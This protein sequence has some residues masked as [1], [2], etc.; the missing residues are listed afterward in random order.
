MQTDSRMVEQRE[1]GV[2]KFAQFADLK[3]VAPVHVGAQLDDGRFARARLEI[4]RPL[5]VEGDGDLV[6]LGW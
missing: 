3:H 5:H 1:Q 6:R 4:E 2:R